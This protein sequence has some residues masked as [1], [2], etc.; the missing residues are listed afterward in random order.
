MRLRFLLLLFLA[1]LFLSP[2]TKGQQTSATVTGTATD[3]SGATLPRVQVRLKELATGLVREAATDSS[4]NFTL[5]FLSA[6]RYSLEASSTGF[7]RYLVEPFELQVGQTARIDL[8]LKLG[9]V[10]QT[11]EVSASAAVLQTE[12]SSVGAVIDSSKIVNL[13]LNGRNFVQLAQLIPGVNPGTPGSITVRRGRGSIGETSRSS[14]ITAMQ[15]NGAR[16]TNNRFYLDGVEFMD[17]DAFSYPF[18]LSIDSIAEFRVETS[19]YSAEYG[20]SPGGQVSIITRRGSNRFNGTLWEFNRNDAL[21]Q[22]RDEIAKKDLPSPRLNRNQYGANVGGPV[23]LP[24]LY[25]GQD[26]TFFFFNWESGR[27]ASGSTAGFRLVPPSEM[28]RGDFS[29]LRNARTN[30]PI[31]LRDPLN[32]GIVGNRIPQSALS[33][34]AVTFL[35]FTPEPNT[36]VGTSNYVSTPFSAVSTQDNYTARV[37]HNLSVKDSLAFRYLWNSTVESGT[38]FWANDVRDNDARTSGIATTWT[39]TV[40]PSI[41]NEFRFGWNQIDE[42]EI[43]GTTNNPDFDIAGM[44]N[45]PLVSRRPV[46]FGPPDISIANGAD[47]NFAVFNLQRQ[48]GP[49]IRGNSGLNFNNI[50][51]WNRGTHFLRAG[52]DILPR[53]GGFDQAR[54]PRGLFRFDGTYTGSAL[55]DFMLGYVKRAEVNTD[56]TT[57]E[58]RSVWQSYFV[59]D[60]WKVRPG[61]TV[62]LGVRYDYLQPLFDAEGRMANIEQ[63]GMFVTR[64]VTP[65]TAKYSRMVRGDKNNFGPR[66]GFAWRP[67]WIPDAVVRAGYGIYYNHIHPGAPGGMTESSQVTTS[68]QVDGP[69]SGN[70]SVFFNDPFRSAQTPQPQLN[71]VPSIDPDYRDAYIQQWNLTVQKQL[72]GRFVVDAGYVGNKSTR[73]SVTIPAMNRPVELVDPR[74]PELASINARRPN[75]A[76]QRSIQGDK[77]IGNSTY[78]S[79]QVRGD[80]RMANGLTS[81][82]AYTWSKCISGPSDI[83]ADIGGGSYIGTVQDIYNLQ[84]ERS[85]CGFHVPHRFVQSLIYDL[86]VFNT[87]SRWTR[88]LLGGWQFATILVAQSGFPGEVAYGIDTTGTGVPSRADSVLGQ[89]AILSRSEKTYDRWFNVDAFAA[90]VFGNYGTSPRTGAVQLP[91]LLNVDFSINKQFR[92]SESRR[93]EIRG[94]FFNLFNQFNADPGSLDRSVRSANFGKIG[95][96][97][98]GVTSRVVQIGAK[99]YF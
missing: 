76:F 88:S 69:L 49:R 93:V 50:L 60:D 8:K 75:Q 92:L 6:S 15:A 28:R 4:G 86:P 95:G 97:I 36:Q 3:P 85:V 43:F 42:E 37:D 66:I 48:I 62:N 41:V 99:L 45:L 55:A 1:S 51:S 16:D 10:T 38:P 61:L 27:H 9:E 33:P 35:K 87:G 23:Q 53:S 26:K 19:T 46:D 14:G 67:R 7:Q 79:L 5:P 25:K 54:N 39:R 84:N 59:Q 30:E 13:P 94:E 17:Y 32:I 63:N 83:G 74:T 73:L 34:Q 98:S 90:P 72:P 96:G 20:A 71:A 44:M 56:L 52:A 91:G 57:T 40:T 68:F 12:S 64:L 77:Q 2:V 81:L 70:P 47:G 29:N 21:T 31:V 58:L 22:T 24:Y 78:H 65:E 11:M 89:T 80:R 18:A 82:T